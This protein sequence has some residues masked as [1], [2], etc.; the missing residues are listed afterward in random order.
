MTGWPSESDGNLTL[1]NFLDVSDQSPSTLTTLY[2][3]TTLRIPVCP[4]IPVNSIRVLAYV[5]FLCRVYTV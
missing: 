3:Y 5:L 2:E 4:G 1:P